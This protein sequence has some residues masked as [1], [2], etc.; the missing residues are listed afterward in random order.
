MESGKIV[1]AYKLWLKENGYKDKSVTRIYNVY[2][3]LLDSSSNEVT[4]PSIGCAL[5]IMGE[6]IDAVLMKDF[7]IG[8][9][10]MQR[11][12][13]IQ[14]AKR[15]KKIALLYHLI[16]DAYGTVDADVYKSIVNY[17]A[18]DDPHLFRCLDCL[19]KSNAGEA[20]FDNDA[21][22]VVDIITTIAKYD[23]YSNTN[24]D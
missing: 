5:D 11:S 1:E 18:A 3:S 20:V 9:C 6:Y 16:L 10:K 7:D 22:V 12:Q 8:I 19:L 24:V 23:L 4:L 2:K 13:V 21:K 14:S 15:L 17:I